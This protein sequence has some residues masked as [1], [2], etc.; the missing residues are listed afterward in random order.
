V[1][2]ETYDVAVVGAGPAGCA[3]AIT[4]A[5]MG[6]RT[7]LLERGTYPRHKVCGEFVSPESHTIL[8][9]LLGPTSPLL[10]T[11]VK[12][13]SARLFADGHC[14]Q[15]HFD[16]PALSI[17]RFDLDHALW[18]AAHNF[19]VDCMV[20]T[21]DCVRRNDAGFEL[22][23]HETNFGI[24]AR[25]VVNAS[26]RWSTLRHPPLARGP[27]WIGLKA[28][29]QGEIAPASTDLYFFHGGYCGVQPIPGNRVN[30][31][32]MVR[33]DVATTPERVFAQHPEL[34]R[35]SRA[36]EVATEL[37]TTAPLVHLPPEP[38]SN[39]M[40]NAGDAAAFLDPFVGDGI[41]I[42]LR[43]GILAARSQTADEYV[44]EY[45][46]AFSKAFQTAAAARRVAQA[47]A[48][49]RHLAFFGL[50]SNALKRWAMQRT[51]GN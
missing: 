41:S 3:A 46:R 9:D 5:R 21:V 51:R 24:I 4:S 22:T 32:A 28:H 23:L 30:A 27:R 13:A 31:S 33:A 11:A 14:V 2:I 36:W 25:K 19:G 44:R 49:A 20:E 26:G 17:S 39:G 15:F 50:N 37:I 38:V 6:Q 48:F 45:M 18:H 47:P 29:F 16:C 42:A 40:F 35:R 12:I 7:A 43:S 10:E 1:E 34:W 8:M